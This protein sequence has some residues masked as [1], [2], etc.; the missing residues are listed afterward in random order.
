MPADRSR[1]RQACPHPRLRAFVKVDIQRGWTFDPGRQARSIKFDD[2]AP[3]SA[4]TARMTASQSRNRTSHWIEIRAATIDAPPRYSVSELIHEYH[5]SSKYGR[6]HFNHAWKIDRPITFI[7]AAYSAT[8]ECCMTITRR[9]PI[10]SNQAGRANTCL[11]RQTAQ[12]RMAWPRSGR[13]QAQ[14]GLAPDHG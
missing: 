9:R 8:E 13:K 5:R 1:V 11:T 10:S 14:S 6:R 4:I 3:Q 2:A 12:Q 7:A